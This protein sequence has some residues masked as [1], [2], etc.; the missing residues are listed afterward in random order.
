MER[1]DLTPSLSLSR[2]VYGMWRLG[3]DEDTSAK[4]VQAKIETCLEHGITT[5]DQADIYGGYEAEAILGNCLKGSPD[6]RDQIEI[7][8]KCDIIAP[9]GRH[10]GARVKHY[11]TSRQHIGASVDQSLELMQI[12]QIDLLLIHRP[13]P[14]MNHVET[15]AT[16]D[17][18]VASG[19]VKAVGVS[20]FKPW[21]WDLL[22]SGMTTKL[23]T[24]QIEMSVLAHDAFTNGDLAF[25]QQRAVSPMAWSPL[26]GG[27]LFG[28]GHTD[29]RDALA[30][31]ATERGVDIAA[32]AIAW[33]LA[34]PAKIVPVLGTNK[35]DRI[36]QS[37]IAPSIEMDRQTWFE[38]YTAAL[39]HEVA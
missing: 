27:A 3:D 25:L 4:H 31:I 15:G 33:L 38:I 32:I 37:A 20:N 6:L 21:D 7:V 2:L 28:N 36:A 26:G 23:A 1:V 13:D 24:N 22:Q 17:D 30:K 5:M 35:L 11:D 8:T 12:E 16:L 18:L 10:S 9:M 19:K 39:G 14:F 34:H 29:V